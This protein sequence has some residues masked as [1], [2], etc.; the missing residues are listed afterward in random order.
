IAI[1]VIALYGVMRLV[2]GWGLWRH[3]I[4]ASWLGCI[5]AAAYLPFELY[6]LWR[7]QDWLTWGVLLVN[8]LIVVVLARDIARRRP[9]GALPAA[10]RGGAR[11]GLLAHDRHRDLQR[12]LVVQAR[13][14]GGTIGARQ[15]H[16]RQFPCATGALGHVLAGQFQVHATQARARRGMDVERLFDLAAD[17]VEAPR[18]VAVAGGFGIAMHGIADPQHAPAV[19]LHGIKQR[20]Q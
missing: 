11:L 10:Q 5:G 2:E 3:R 8:L 7:H 16:I 18:L 6:A 13:I 14:D 1:A 12:L 15:V 19:S 4:W 20:R 17:V 9:R